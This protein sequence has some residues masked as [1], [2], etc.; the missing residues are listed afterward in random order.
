MSALLLLCLAS[1]GQ[2]QA[3]TGS[4]SRKDLQDFGGSFL[5]CFW[6][7]GRDS[8]KGES[9]PVA[10]SAWH[11]SILQWEVLEERNENQSSGKLYKTACD[12]CSD[13]KVPPKEKGIS[14][15]DEFPRSLCDCQ[16]NPHLILSEG[17]YRTDPNHREI[18]GPL[19]QRRRSEMEQFLI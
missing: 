16:A 11:L 19:H 12:S 9:H 5:A 1:G 14:V 7:G 17:C 8:G 3:Q 18:A 10:F 2:S 6:Q 13:F 4:L 15:Y